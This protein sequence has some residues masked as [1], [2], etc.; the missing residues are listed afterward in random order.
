MQSLEDIA[1]KNLIFNFFKIHVNSII[2]FF[3]NHCNNPDV[4]SFFYDFIVPHIKQ[5]NLPSIYYKSFLGHINELLFMLHLSAIEHNSPRVCSCN[6]YNYNKNI[7]RTNCFEERIFQ[8]FLIEIK[9]VLTD[10]DIFKVLWE[11]YYN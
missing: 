8:F 6:N 9:K 10:F 11:E 3:D 4:I 7:V 5:L 2:I 1:F